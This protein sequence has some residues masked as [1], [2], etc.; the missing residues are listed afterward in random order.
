MTMKANKQLTAVAIISRLFAG[1]AA[2]EQPWGETFKTYRYCRRTSAIRCAK[3][4]GYVL[5]GVSV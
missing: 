4:M 2:M 1:I 5:P 3:L